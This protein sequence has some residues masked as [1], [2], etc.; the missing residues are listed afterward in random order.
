MNEELQGIV[1]RMVQAGESEQDIALVIK[2]YVPKNTGVSSSVSEAAPSARRPAPVLGDIVEQGVRAGG[3]YVG[4]LNRGVTE[5]L[6]SQPIKLLGAAD[7]AFGRLIGDDHKSILT[8]AGE[9]AERFIRDV[10]PVSQET[11][12]SLGGQ[13]ARGIGTAGGIMAT[14]GFGQLGAGGAALEAAVPATV[15]GAAGILGKQLLK[16][17]SFVGGAM[18]AIP[19]YEAAK[20]A[21]LSD[22]EAFGT[23]VKNYFVGQT[24]ALPIEAMFGRLNRLTGGGIGK[25]IKAIAA[26]VGVGGFTEAVQEGVQTYLTNK[27]AAGDYD[28]DRDPFWGIADAMTVGGIVGMIIPGVGG[29]IKSAS[30]ENRVK[31]ERK[32]QEVQAKEATLKQLDAS[33]EQTSTGEPGVDKAIDQ[34]SKLS[35][36]Q[37]T[38][39]QDNKLA[40]A[41]EDGAQADFEQKEQKA[42]EVAQVNK[43]ADKAVKA[44]EDKA[45][46]ISALKEQLSDKEA[47]GDKT[48]IR[49]EL[50]ELQRPKTKVFVYGTLTDPLTRKEA[51]GEHVESEAAAIKGLAKE[52]GEFS[53]LKDA[54]DAE[55]PGQMLSLTDEQLKKLDAWE[56]NYTRQEIEPGV[57]AYVR[58]PEI[59]STGKNQVKYNDAIS[60]VTALQQRFAAANPEEDLTDL[61]R[62][63]SE[64]KSVLQ[65]IAGAPHA[66][67][68]TK[69]QKGIEDATGITKP[70]KSVTMTPGEAIKHQVQTFYK[71]KAEGV[72]RGAEGKNE[73][74]TKVQEAMKESALTP[75]QISTILTKLKKTNLSTAGSISRLNTYIDK[76]TADAD[77][78]DKLHEAQGLRKRIKGK[79][80]AEGATYREREALRNF[81]KVDPEETDVDAYL[82]AANKVNDSFK[83]VKDRQV[84][85]IAATQAYTDNVRGDMEKAA[86]AKQHDRVERLAEKLGITE[87]EATLL[88][89]EG[90]PADAQI[91][92]AT[93]KAEA[94][95]EMLEMAYEAKEEIPGIDGLTTNQAKDIEALK[96]VDLELLST[97]QLKFYVKT[98]DRLNTNEDFGGLGNFSAIV[99]AQQEFVTLQNKMKDSNIL[100]L[101]QFEANV[102]SL[103]MAIQAITGLPEDAAMFQLYM[104]MKG[105]NDASVKSLQVEADFVTKIKALEE[106]LTRAYGKKNNGFSSE[107]I[108]RQGI[109]SELIRY[110]ED[111]DPTEALAA[112]KQAVEQTVENHKQAGESEEA[113]TIERLYAP[114]KGLN[115]MTIEEVKKIM[116]KVDPAGAKIIETAIEFYGPYAD[117]LAEYNERFFNKKTIKSVNYSGPRKWRSKGTEEVEDVQEQALGDINSYISSIAKP[118]QVASAKEF[119][120][121]VRPDAV[122]DFNKHHNMANGIKRVVFGMEA[123]TPMIQV[124]ENVKRK[125]DMLKLFGKKDGDDKSIKKAESLFKKLFAP[126]EQGGADAGAYF[127]FER[128]AAGRAIPSE[129][130]RSINKIFNPLRK[131]GYTLSLSGLSQVPK[132]AT[133]L[134][135]VM[136]NL[137]EDSDLLSIGEVLNNKKEMNDFIAGETVAMRGA[138]KSSFTLGELVPSQIAGESEKG[139]E[140]WLEKGFE[141]WLG[142]K[143]LVKTDVAM[144]K[145]TYLAFYKQYL[146]QK[147]IKYEGLAKE[148]SMR[149]DQVRQEARAYAKQKTDTLQ[150]VSNPAELGTKMKDQSF[151]WQAIKAALVPFGTF[152]SNA[153]SRMWA[154][155]RAMIN[156]NPKQRAAGAKDLLATALEQGVFHTT[157]GVLK[158]YLWGALGH[159]IAGA[160]NLP[161]DKEKDR[162]RAWDNAVKV[163]KTNLIIDT[164]PLILTA[165]GEKVLVDLV[166]HAAK[167][168]TDYDDP[169]YKGPLYKYKGDINDPLSALT[170]IT[171]VYG[172]VASRVGDAV[173]AAEEAITEERRTRGGEIKKLTPE[174]ERFAIFVGMLHGLNL[175]GK[176]P[177]DVLFA[178]DK[179][180]NNQTPG[181]KSPKKSED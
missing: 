119:K 94:R 166:N 112:T 4:Q 74:V 175:A 12:Q 152:S 178:I 31:L 44:E 121:L 47:T 37:I 147:G 38:V 24:E 55:T 102:D 52:D 88:L 108:V 150:V 65:Q 32:L 78:A 130:D 27:I 118:K 51:L 58:K 63:L 11:E 86:V 171:G 85:D 73:L 174:Q 5:T 7:E 68:K 158:I 41:A 45:E 129:V 92:D 1:E 98:V 49:E 120:N 113:A 124:R 154:D 23:L 139:F 105:I 76:V 30:P 2:S 33:L 89:A 140:N 36:E 132:Q 165:P 29:V 101:N 135:N 159:A 164:L 96:T 19:E 61:Y 156:G 71:G 72:R 123:I 46:Q 84:L 134:A 157:S 151:A 82:T 170:D 180:R 107:S 122:L 116:S 77:Y 80:N 173:G 14:A 144:A 161:P 28:P 3:E 64:A 42:K 22:D 6:T 100:N 128:H 177:A 93:R 39:V 148:N 35:S 136:V 143:P 81:S 26:G 126:G 141:G 25:N 103:P 104:G 115:A 48:A 90:S 133:V 137:G 83:P 21:G 176:L 43:D 18:T 169:S 67:S 99:K 10:N 15:P 181:K 87:E 8:S 16:P 168:L 57:Y 111:Q 149:S 160:F 131:W 162:Q 50:K 153:K 70:D 145:I 110:A 109:Y 75:R 138:Q 69:T 53:T 127:D 106:M 13:V 66:R 54:P 79:S 167:R 56:T 17:A 62:Q 155:Y 9:S 117:P 34:E 146:R 97:D 20:A 40:A 172:V 163:W 95:E 125:Q 114:F 142:I 60:Q 179:V 91:A 59:D